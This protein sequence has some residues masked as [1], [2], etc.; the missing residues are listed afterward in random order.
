VTS[1]PTF[2]RQELDQTIDELRAIGG[3][4]LVPIMTAVRDFGIAFA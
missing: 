2:T 3:D 4:H 1:Q